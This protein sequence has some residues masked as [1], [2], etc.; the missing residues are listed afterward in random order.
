MT[1]ADFKVISGGDGYEDFSSS[2][3]SDLAGGSKN[4]LKLFSVSHFLEQYQY[5][6][7]AT[8]ITQR[9]HPNQSRLERPLRDTTER[10]HSER[11]HKMTRCTAVPLT[12]NGLKI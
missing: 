9:D 7:N 10:D 5:Q 1:V 6:C 12:Q 11:L 8:E 3:S 2:A 4:Q